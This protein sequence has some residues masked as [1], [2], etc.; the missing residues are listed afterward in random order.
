MKRKVWIAFEYLVE[1][2]DEKQ[3]EMAVDNA[4]ESGYLGSWSSSGWSFEKTGKSFEVEKP[5]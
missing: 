5:K 3:I 2:E 1:G 4:M